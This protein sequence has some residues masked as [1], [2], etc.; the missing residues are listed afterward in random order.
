MKLEFEVE[1]DTGVRV[2]EIF[3]ALLKSGGLTGVKG[4]FT[5][6]HFDTEG[7]FQKI[8]LRYFPW[9]RRSNK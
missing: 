2:Q 5:S 3:K 9:Q 4:G 7:I 8:E 6:I 1:N